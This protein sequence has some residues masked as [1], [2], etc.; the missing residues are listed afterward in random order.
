MLDPFDGLMLEPLC[1]WS[2]NED[3]RKNSITAAAVENKL[4]ILAQLLQRIAAPRAV[5]VK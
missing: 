2:Y 1:Q 4:R 5:P 3:V